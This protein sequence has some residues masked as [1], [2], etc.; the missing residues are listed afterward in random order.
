MKRLMT[1]LMSLLLCAVLLFSYTSCALKVSAEDLTEGYSRTAADVAL[2]SEQKAAGQTAYHDF[3]FRLFAQS[4]RDSGTADQK[5]RMISPLS[6]MMCLAMIANGAGGNTKTQLEEALGLPVDDL[7]A[8]L[9][10]F[11]QN[12]YT[13]DDCKVALADS[14]WFQNDANRLTVEPSFLQSVTDWYGAEVYAAPF[15]RSTVRDV[16]NWCKEQT[17]GMIE[18]IIDDIDPDAVMYLI[19]ALTFDAKW[20]EEYEKDDIEDDVFTNADGTTAKVKM[21][22]SDELYYLSG[23]GFEGFTRPYKNWRY[24]FVGLLPAEG[25]DVLDFAA[26]LTADVWQEMW[27]E[28]HKEPEVG[29]Y[30]GVRAGIPEFSFDFDIPLNDVLE[31]LGMTDMFDGDLADFA[32][33]AQ[34]SRGNIWCALVE[35]KT[36]IG[37]DRNGTKA[38]AI[39]W[40]A[41]NDEA[42]FAYADQH[43]VI[44]DRPFVYA[45]ADTATGLPLFIGVV[46]D[47]D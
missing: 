7:N 31:Q 25:T 35:Q 23:D 47:L 27:T 1:V 42:A 11:R 32:P 2:T 38:A 39:T 24:E 29:W 17:D 6:A 46:T 43:T 20:M 44:L 5:N 41:M 12:L 19:N 28:G 21:L 8:F 18:K 10:D 13:S 37:L 45:I 36:H 4:V 14:V 15:D 33:M 3:A 40:G 9:Y 30:E 16:N 34:S 26:S 22:H